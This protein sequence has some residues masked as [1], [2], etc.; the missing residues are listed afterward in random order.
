MC[1]FTIWLA[2]YLQYMNDSS[3]YGVE[4]DKRVLFMKNH[5]KFDCPNQIM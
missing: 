2:T 4:F 3:A 5:E 1:G